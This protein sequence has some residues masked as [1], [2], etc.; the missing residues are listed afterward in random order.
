MAEKLCPL[1]FSFTDGS[2]I[3]KLAGLVDCESDRCEWWDKESQGCHIAIIGR[4][5]KSLHKDLDSV[6]LQ[7]QKMQGQ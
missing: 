4:F 7:L 3:S 1:K 6:Q 5:M 2:A